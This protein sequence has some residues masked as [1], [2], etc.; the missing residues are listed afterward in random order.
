MAEATEFWSPES[1]LSDGAELQTIA[2]YAEPHHS[3]GE[4][5]DQLA[6]RL[7]NGELTGTGMIQSAALNRLIEAERAG[8]EDNAK[9]IWQ[10][11]SMELWYR[12]A[13]SKGV[14]A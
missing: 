5:L 6:A 8:R 12:N 4:E 2:G 3:H 13:R 1:N 9:Q 7:V 10:L 11:L 14:A